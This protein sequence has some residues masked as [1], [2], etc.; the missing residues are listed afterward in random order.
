M[1]LHFINLTK[2]IL[3]NKFKENDI[4]ILEVLQVVLFG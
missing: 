4:R 2:D 3:R 1:N